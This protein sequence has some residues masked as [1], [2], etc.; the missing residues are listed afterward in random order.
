[1]HRDR[2]GGRPLVGS[3]GEADPEEHNGRMTLFRT[4]SRFGDVTNSPVRD[5]LSVLARDD[6]IS[7]AGGI[8]DAKLF[9][10]EELRAA[11]E[12]VLTRQAARALQ[13]SA[14]EGEPEFREQ[15]AVRMSRHL[16]TSLDEV[17][18][19]SGSQEGIYLVGQALLDPGD[20]VLVE[21]PTYLAAVQAF[22]MSGARMVPVESDAD[23]VLPD[24]LAAAI[25]AHRPKF[26]YLIPTFQNPTGRSMSLARRLE[27][28]DVL[29]RTGTP[30]VEDDPYGELRFDG[31]PV[32]PLTAMPG[33]APQSILLNSASKVM[34]PGLRIG[35]LRAEGEVMRVIDVAKQAVGLQTSVPDQLVIA[36]YLATCDLDAHIA[37]IVDVYRARRDTM[38]T[39][40]EAV[41]PAGAEC[42]RP[43][44]G[45]FCWIDLGGM[46]DTGALLPRAVDHGVAYVPGW[47]F[48]AAEPNRATMRLSFVTN[49]HDT[50]REGVRRLATAY[51][52]GR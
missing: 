26:V 45:M 44:G 8:P 31:D 4:A 14:T 17:H 2:A 51:G 15:A 35:W 34:A 37:G 30:L 42:N 18:V 50:I 38:V 11:Y 39:A 13:Y 16:P 36:R 12:F 29:L 23:G 52:W 3:G 19:T 41:L 27:V 33:L 7:F 28:A 24:V 1:M 47:A 40:L 22:G 20:V 5:I 48:Y 49:D 6:V 10:Y 32:P 43:A 21:Q 9:A 25:A 46:T